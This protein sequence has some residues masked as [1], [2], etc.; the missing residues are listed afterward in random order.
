ML[1]L[2]TIKEISPFFNVQ[3]PAVVAYLA[4]HKQLNK[5]VHTAILAHPLTHTGSHL[6]TFMQ[7]YSCNNKD[8]PHIVARY[9]NPTEWD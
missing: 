4:Q 8:L 1:I 3:L 7:N 5:Q 6:Y 9:R 2:A